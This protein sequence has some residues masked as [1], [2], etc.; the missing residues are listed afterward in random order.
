MEAPIDDTGALTDLE[1]RLAGW[2]PSREGLV[3]DQLLFAAGRTAGR[4]SWPIVTLGLGLVSVVLTIGLVHERMS[5]LELLAQ[6]K[7]APPLSVPPSTDKLDVTQPSPVEPPTSGSYLTSRVALSEGLDAWS[8][9][10]TPNRSDRNDPPGPVL[11]A[12][13]LVE[14]IDP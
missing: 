10:A 9:A 8:S 7:L 1:R 3:A 13:S 5:R 2:R 14:D 12:H 4:S 6:L 11:K